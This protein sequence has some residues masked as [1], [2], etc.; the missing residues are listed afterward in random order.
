MVVERNRCIT[1]KKPAKESTLTIPDMITAALDRRGILNKWLNQ[2]PSRKPQPLLF[3]G[4]DEHLSAR[5]GVS[6]IDL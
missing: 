2:H 4:R 3:P 1:M 5:P 6:C